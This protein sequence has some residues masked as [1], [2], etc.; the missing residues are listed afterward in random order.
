M[1]SQSCFLDAQSE[2][3]SVMRVLL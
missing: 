3:P 2:P 1:V